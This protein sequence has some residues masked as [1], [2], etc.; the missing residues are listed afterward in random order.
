MSTPTTSDYLR[1]LLVSLLVV[2]LGLTPYP[3]AAIRHLV[4]ANRAISTGD[5]LSAS[6]N[7]AEAGLEF[8]WRYDLN[9]KAGYYALEAGDPKAAIQYLERPGTISHLSYSDKIKLGEAYD[10]A[11]DSLMAEAIWKDLVV[12]VDS[13]QVHEHLLSLY[14]QQLDY[15]SAVNELQALLFLNP[16]DI[17]LYYQI[18]SI[19]SAIDPIKAL[20]FLIQAAELDSD[21]GAIAR[22]LH[23]KIRTATLFDEPSYT[24]LIAGRQL[25]N[26]SN[27]ELAA[28]AFQQATLIQPTY[29]EA[30]AFLGEARQQMAIQETGTV[31]VAGLYELDRALQVDPDSILANTFMGIYW[32]RQEDYQ[33][34]LIYMQ[35]AVNLSTNDAFLFTEFGNL[36][37]KAGDLTAA[38]AAYERAIQ[39][40]PGDPLFYRLLADFALQN[41]IQTRELALPAARQ[42]VSL[43]PDDPGSLDVMAQVMLALQDYRSAERFLELAL[44]SDPSYAPAYLHLGTAYLYLGE[45]KLAQ[46]WL[47]QA[48]AVETESWISSQ[49]RRML[50]YYFP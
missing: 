47:S 33:R 2:I 3:Q 17:H 27:W 19:Y 44:Q 48:Q 15:A 49:A 36:L 9:I 31:S 21:N 11:G 35:R 14:L 24:H 12:Q 43:A 30:W 6:Q 1:I 16:S 32:E 22:A 37:A 5:M 23:D 34:A 46:H 20:P 18:G 40:S 8:P 28:V 29:A 4:D 50:E 41:N 45:T 39:L 26:T 38:R 7:L 10:Q 25:A 42:A 13:R